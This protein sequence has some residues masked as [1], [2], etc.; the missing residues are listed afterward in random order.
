MLDLLIMVH[1]AHEGKNKKREKE[2]YNKNAT[3]VQ[4]I[5]NG[6]SFPKLEILY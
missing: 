6:D 3:K 4:K 1:S 5:K 2:N